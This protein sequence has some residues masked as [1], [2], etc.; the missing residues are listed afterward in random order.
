MT[1]IMFKKPTRWHNID[2]DAVFIELSSQA[3]GLTQAEAERR[4]V[5]YGPNRLR[6]IKKRSPW[7]LLENQFKNILIYVLLIA[8]GITALIGHWADAAVIAG[9]SSIRE[10]GRRCSL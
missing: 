4:F 5:E 8:A 6:P 1:K 10:P 2:L 9:I 3:D 7:V